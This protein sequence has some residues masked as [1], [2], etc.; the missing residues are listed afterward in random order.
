MLNKKIQIIFVCG[1]HSVHTFLVSPCKCR[2]NNHHHQVQ[3]KHCSTFDFNNIFLKV[4]WIFRLYR[5]VKFDEE[6]RHE[7][8]THVKDPLI[9]FANFMMWSLILNKK[10][11][12]TLSHPSVWLCVSRIMCCVIAITSCFYFNF[13]SFLWI[14]LDACLSY[15]YIFIIWLI[16]F[17]FSFLSIWNPSSYKKLMQSVVK[18]DKI[19]LTYYII[20]ARE[21]KP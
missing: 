6:R 2:C 12:Y 7:Y 8:M 21:I 5:D 18:R 20:C 19:K 15:M 14:F 4:L 16:S 11:T 3:I 13:T 10:Q 17:P 9:K 1:C